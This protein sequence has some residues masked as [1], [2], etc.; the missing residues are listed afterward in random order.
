M[1]YSEADDEMFNKFSVDISMSFSED[2]AFCLKSSP[3][4]HV[5]LY[6]GQDDFIINTQGAERWIARLD[7]PQIRSWQAA[8]KQLWRVDSAA[9]APVAGTVQILE[10]FFFAVVWK[11]GHLV[12]SNQPAAALDLISR[13]IHNERNWT[14]V[15]ADQAASESIK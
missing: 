10:N 5:L 11:A 13:F 14:S 4:F 1:T 8:P 12:P 6:N 2:V 9:G 3:G 15:A 7:W